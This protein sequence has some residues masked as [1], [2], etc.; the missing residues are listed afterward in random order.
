M[1]QMVKT[2]IQLF[3][4]T[5]TTNTKLFILFISYNNNLSHIGDSTWIWPC[6]PMKS[7]TWYL[8]RPQTCVKA[9]GYYQFYL[10]TVRNSWV[11]ELVLQ[12]FW[13]HMGSAWVWD[14]HSVRKTTKL[15]FIARSV[16]SR[17]HVWM[18]IL[19]RSYVLHSALCL[20]RHCS[21]VYAHIYLHF[22]K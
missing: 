21:S 2:K 1:S 17:Y 3:F 15:K 6:I 11:R 18:N 12:L 13:E 14:C 22:Y 20:L 5:T 9:V 16:Q 7:H 8:C 10:L 19:Y 4:K